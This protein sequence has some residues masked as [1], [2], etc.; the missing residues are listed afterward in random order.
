MLVLGVQRIDAGRISAERENRP[1]RDGD[2]RTACQQVCAADAIVFG[3]L[4]DPLSAVSRRKQ[5]LDPLRP[6]R[7]TQHATAHDLSGEGGQRMKLATVNERVSGLVLDWPQRRFWVLGFAGAFALLLL[8]TLAVGWLLF[9]GIG[10]WGVN[11]PV[12][13]GF[14]IVNSVV[15]DRDRTRWDVYF[16]PF[17]FCCTKS[18]EPASTALRRR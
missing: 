18:G 14:A 6:A 3:D 4:A 9:H 13:W 16:W 2:V 12:A 5:D 7:R 8:L 11:V 10:I 15:V 17:C 1:L